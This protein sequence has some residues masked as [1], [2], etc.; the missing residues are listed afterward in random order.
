MPSGLTHRIRPVK[1][2]TFAR[3]SPHEADLDRDCAD[4]PFSTLSEAVGHEERT[5]K[6]PRPSLS[7]TPFVRLSIACCALGHDGVGVRRVR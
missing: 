5:F 4:Y 7:T 1:P 2:T 3:L 6:S